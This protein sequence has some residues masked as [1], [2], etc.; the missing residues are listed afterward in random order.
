[1]KF[2]KKLALMLMEYLGLFLFF[3]KLTEERSNKIQ[4]NKYIKFILFSLKFEP[5]IERD[6]TLIF[7]HKIIRSITGT[8]MSLYGVYFGNI[9]FVFLKSKAFC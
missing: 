1:M 4:I 2:E 9:N 3:P 6:T 8:E 7:S 5:S